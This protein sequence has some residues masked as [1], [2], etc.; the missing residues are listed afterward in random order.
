MLV[1]D[2]FIRVLVVVVDDVARELL[3]LQF[4]ARG[5]VDEAVDAGNGGGPG[6]GGEVGVR[7]GG[8]EGRRRD[9]EGDEM[10]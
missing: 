10:P 8:A 6:F 2:A 1:S 7:G 5:A 3:A 9:I 4:L